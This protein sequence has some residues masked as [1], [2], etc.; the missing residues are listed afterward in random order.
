MNK[1]SSTDK[2]SILKSFDKL[3]LST[4]K[5]LIQKVRQSQLTYLQTPNITKLT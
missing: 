1:S 3:S 4:L 2:H 5:Q